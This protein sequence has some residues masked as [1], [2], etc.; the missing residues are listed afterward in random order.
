MLE[1]NKAGSSRQLRSP[2]TCGQPRESKT[3]GRT[4]NVAA[5][6]TINT[7]HPARRT[8][9]HIHRSRFYSEALALT[10]KA[11]LPKPE[12]STG[13]ST[14][15]RAVA[16]ESNFLVVNGPR[17]RLRVRRVSKSERHNTNST[18]GTKQQDECNN[19]VRA[20][21]FVPKSIFT[22]QL[23]RGALSPSPGP[24]TSPLFGRLTGS[25]L[26]IGQQ[27]CVSQRHYDNLQKHYQKLQ[28][29]P[30]RSSTQYSQ[31]VVSD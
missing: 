15:A 3:N 27:H 4:R 31:G 12:V 25:S 10:L 24:L 11:A 8:Q 14:A 13:T 1:E 6:K 19:V 28:D 23:D 16:G 22:L 9:V 30:S 21:T 29:K 18:R 2:D 26:L 20:G 5:G 7:I 17:K